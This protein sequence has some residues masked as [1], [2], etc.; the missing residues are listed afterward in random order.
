MQIFAHTAHNKEDVE[1]SGEHVRVEIKAHSY[2]S[3]EAQNFRIHRDLD[4]M[5]ILLF[6]FCCCCCNFVVFF[7]F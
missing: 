5:S 1:F 7:S 4:K 2:V 6:G 3:S